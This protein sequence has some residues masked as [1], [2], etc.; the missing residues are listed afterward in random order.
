MAFQEFVRG[1]DEGR[2]VVAEGE[3]PLTLG[4]GY[5]ETFG[6]G[7]AFGSAVAPEL[8]SLPFTFTGE[9]GI[10]DLEIL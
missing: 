9:I 6:N 1:S 10:L 8:F 4:A 2:R 5:S 3:L 7:N